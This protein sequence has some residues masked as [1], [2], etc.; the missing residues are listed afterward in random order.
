MLPPPLPA[1]LRAPVAA[2]AAAGGL[3]DDVIGAVMV[4]LPFA[5]VLGA[6]LASLAGARGV[7]ERIRR[8]VAAAVRTWRAPESV[9]FHDEPAGARAGDAAATWPR[10]RHA[11]QLLD[12]YHRFAAVSAILLRLD[13]GDGLWCTVAIRF[14]GAVLPR[15]R[16]RGAHVLA[17][18]AAS[19]PARLPAGAVAGPGGAAPA[20]ALVL[21]EGL[22]FLVDDRIRVVAAPEPRAG[23]AVWR[24]RLA[25]LRRM[26]AAGRLE[27]CVR[28]AVVLLDATH[29]EAL[30]EFLWRLEHAERRERI[31]SPDRD[32]PGGGG[33]GSPAPPEPPPP[34]DRRPRPALA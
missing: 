18:F 27:S 15:R 7:G 5:A 34:A 24:V 23:G 2:L 17:W 9:A 10:F 11:E 21:D 22:V 31:P 19:D 13:V 12:T 6:L 30:R 32:D 20:D 29:Q 33:D 16:Q 25:D 3:T 8:T 28:G 1:Q 26:A 4:V 14:P